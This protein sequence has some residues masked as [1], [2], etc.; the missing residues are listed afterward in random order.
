MLFAEWESSRKDMAMSSGRQNIFTQLTPFPITVF[1]SLFTGWLLTDHLY[2]PYGYCVPCLRAT[3][4]VTVNNQLCINLRESRSSRLV[5]TGNHRHVNIHDGSMLFIVY[6]MAKRRHRWNSKIINSFC[7]TIR[8]MHFEPDDPLDF[9][10]V[11]PM[12][13]ILNTQMNVVKC[14]ICSSYHY[15]NLQITKWHLNI[16]SAMPNWSVK[17]DVLSRYWLTEITIIFT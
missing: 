17:L 13:N 1:P 16:Q 2:Y 6:D 5:L 14:C 11:G 12:S 9:W 7:I 15:Y 4:V 10:L 3:S 8:R